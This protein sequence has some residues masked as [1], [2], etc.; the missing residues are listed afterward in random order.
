MPQ[1]YKSDENKAVII[2]KNTRE[3]PLLNKKSCGTDGSVHADERGTSVSL[4][5]AG[6]ETLRSHT[7][8]Q[9]PQTL[10]KNIYGGVFTDHVHVTTLPERNYGKETIVSLS[11]GN[12]TQGA[13]TPG[14]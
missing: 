1:S 5:L 10:E 6:P 3:Q 13:A 14:N 11:A 9:P 8:P 2:V 4:S 7:S 12:K